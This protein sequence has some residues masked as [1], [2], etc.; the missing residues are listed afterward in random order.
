V[1]LS[2]GVAW[3]VREAAHH[4]LEAGTVPDKAGAVI[5]LVVIGAVG[6]GC[7]LLLAH[8]VRLTEVTEV[9]GVVLRRRSRRR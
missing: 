8:L 1:A 2:T 7:Y 6:G 5:S 9:L 3:L 4:L